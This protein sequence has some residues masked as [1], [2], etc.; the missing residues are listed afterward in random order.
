MNDKQVILHIKGLR[1]ESIAGNVIVD[2]VDLTLKQGEVLG[3]IGESGAG[4]STIGLSGMAYARAGVHIAGGEVN[5]GGTNIRE[6]DA[7]G[8]RGM[9]GKRIAYI[10]QSAAAA[11]NPAHTL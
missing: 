11:F 2:N 5:L 3:L 4:K 9:R 7:D 6:L 10:A 1:L 8:R